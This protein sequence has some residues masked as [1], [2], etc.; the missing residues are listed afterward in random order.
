MLN[1]NSD[2]YGNFYA[3]HIE[4]IRNAGGCERHRFEVVQ[5]AGVGQNGSGSARAYA[6]LQNLSAQ[7]LP[8]EVTE[9]GETAVAGADEATALT[10]AMTWRLARSR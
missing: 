9:F 4:S 6:T 8:L 3:Q 5:H 2:Q 1:N 10:T 7:G